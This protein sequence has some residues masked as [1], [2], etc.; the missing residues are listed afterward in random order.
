MNRRSSNVRTKIWR[1][2][3]LGDAELLRGRFVDHSYDVHTHDKACFA[4]ITRGA[5]RIKMR[6]T[7]FTATAGDL[8]AV[9]ADEP[10]AGWPL[11]SE[12]WSLRTVYV[13]IGRLQAC[14][15]D[16][17]PGA[18]TPVLAGPVI[19][20]PDLFSLLHG[21]HCCSENAGPALKR[22]E[23]YLGFVARLFERHVRDPGAVAPQFPE[24]RAVRLARDFLDHRVDEKVS[25]GDIAGV[26]GLSPFRLFRAFEQATGM[27][28]HSY[29]RQARV[30]LA[31]GLIRLGR[32]LVEVAVESGFADQAHLTRS[33]RRTLGVTPGEY[34]NA[35]AASKALTDD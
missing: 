12:G 15:N 23:H 27:S 33:F 32:P 14:L 21:I 29:Q 20:D 30:R 6:G 3:D 9:D 35:T 17:A 13:E 26:A 2:S 28:P 22:E 10:H 8:F 11:D 24:D 16:A 1:A 19:R 25:L 7:E 18:V 4:L 5:I 34:R 31:S